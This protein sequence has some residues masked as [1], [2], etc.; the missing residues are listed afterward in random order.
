VITRV[1][2]GS[3]VGSEVSEFVAAGAAVAGAQAFKASMQ[4]RNALAA[5]QSFVIE[6]PL[7]EVWI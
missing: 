3:A 4:R 7:R 5:G 6:E 1:G 2:D